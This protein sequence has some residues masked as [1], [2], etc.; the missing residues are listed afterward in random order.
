MREEEEGRQQ[1]GQQREQQYQNIFREQNGKNR[2]TRF[3]KVNFCPVKKVTVPDHSFD[4]RV[5]SRNP[6]LIC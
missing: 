6:L 5:S 2:P 3:S 4:I 1:R